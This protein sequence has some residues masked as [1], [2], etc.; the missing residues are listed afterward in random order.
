MTPRLQVTR[1]GEPDHNRPGLVAIQEGRIAL[2]VP[3]TRP[4]PSS[5]GILREMK[6]EGP[7]IGSQD[8]AGES[9][10][11]AEG[12]RRGFLLSLSLR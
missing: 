7:R 10:D 1:A 9:G 11:R 4:G 8:L 3:K 12:A 5:L 6:L 2:W